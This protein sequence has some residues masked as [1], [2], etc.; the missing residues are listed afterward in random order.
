[1][2]L[3]SKFGSF[4]SSVQVKEEEVLVVHS[5]WMRKGIYAPEEYASFLDFRKQIAEQYNN[6]IILKRI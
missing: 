2:E 3:K 6:K 1:M 4:H 5:L